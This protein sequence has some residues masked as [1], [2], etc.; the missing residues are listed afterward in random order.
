MDGD[1]IAM[2][3]RERDRLRVMALVLEGKRRQAEAARLPGVT[4][5]TIRGW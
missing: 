5:R 3:Q 2:S 4:E 1:R